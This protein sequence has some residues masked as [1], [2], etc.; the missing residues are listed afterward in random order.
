MN[1]SLFQYQPIF[2]P[3]NLYN[4]MYGMPDMFMPNFSGFNSLFTPPS[5]NV[6]FNKQSNNI[7]GFLFQKQN[8]PA[9]TLT[10]LNTN[11]T[12]PSL[13]KAGYNKEKA[14]KLASE[15]SSIRTGFDGYC[16]R[17]VKEAIQDAGLGKYESGH[18]YKLADILSDNKN[19]KEVRVDSVK[20]LPAGCVLVY[21]KGTAGYSSQYG[22]TEI[23]L[24][25]GTAS[26][27]GITRNLREGARVFVPV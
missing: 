15:I 2:T 21:D 16:A 18:A 9:P 4:P 8:N 19:F 11:T 6:N 17:H 3:L 27:G 20:T 26:S 22:H 1:T 23:T 14:A 5:F 12:L 10:K 13:T 7:F 25:N 24:G